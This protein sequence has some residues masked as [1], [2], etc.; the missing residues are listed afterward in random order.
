ME[1][2]LIEA[3]DKRWDGKQLTNYSIH[4]M[5]V[6]WAARIGK[7]LMFLAGTTIVLD[8]IGPERLKTWGCTFTGTQKEAGY[9]SHPLVRV[10][11][12]DFDL[13]VRID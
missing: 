2:T 1:I 7:L 3:W 11:G 6:L 12:D 4:G 9:I 5:S 10:S 8:R 13:V